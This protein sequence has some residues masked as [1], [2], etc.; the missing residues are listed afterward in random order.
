MIGKCNCGKKA[1]AEYTIQTR[2]KRSKR[3]VVT[4]IKLCESC[5]PRDHYNLQHMT[6]IDG[7]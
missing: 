3:F 1:T 7:K 4:T 6:L 2:I 5:K